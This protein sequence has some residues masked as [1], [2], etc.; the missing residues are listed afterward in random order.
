MSSDFREAHS[1]GRMAIAGGPRICVLCV[2]WAKS[3]PAVL[4]RLSQSLHSL[5]RGI[6][7]QIYRWQTWYSKGEVTCVGSGIK[8]IEADFCNIMSFPCHFF[9]K[10]CLWSSRQWAF[11][12]F[13]LLLNCWRK[14][15]ED[16]L[17]QCRE[18]VCME[19]PRGNP[20]GAASGLPGSRWMMSLRSQTEG[21]TLCRRVPGG[22][23]L[24]TVIGG[25]IVV[26]SGAVGGFHHKPL[27]NQS[28]LSS[29][30]WFA[31]VLGLYWKCRVLE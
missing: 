24:G 29:C 22:C 9:H 5:E 19:R 25:L 16:H 20:W 11:V 30:L 6:I 31:E 10:H 26:W 7:A 8:K 1:W 13:F 27:S 17:C 28:F 4:C 12:D 21:I 2:W 14:W 15:L 3:V 23:S 18:L